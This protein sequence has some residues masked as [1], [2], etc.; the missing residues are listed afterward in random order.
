MLWRKRRRKRPIKKTQFNSF[1]L[2]SFFEEYFALPLLPLFCCCFLLFLRSIPNH[3][4]IWLKN[5]RFCI[6]GAEQ[7]KKSME[8]VRKKFKF[9]WSWSAPRAT[10]ISTIQSPWN[11]KNIKVFVYSFVVE[12]HFVRLRKNMHTIFVWFARRCVFFSCSSLRL[13]ALAGTDQMPVHRSIGIFIVRRNA[14]ERKRKE[15]SI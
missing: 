10:P 12:C 4:V 1:L 8:I 14:I 2:A 5:I 9:F 15:H 11:R 13:V 7:W 6:A 3:L